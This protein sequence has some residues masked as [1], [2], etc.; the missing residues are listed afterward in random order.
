MFGTG[1]GYALQGS[2]LDLGPPQ[3]D[4]RFASLERTDLGRGSWIDHQAGW[5]RGSDALLADL[6]GALPWRQRERPMYERV[7]PEPRLTSWLPVGT[8]ELPDP[9]GL[10]ADLLGERYSRPIRTIGCNWYRDG[11]D[12]VAWHGDRVPRPGDALVA[13]VSIGARRPFLLRPHGGGPSRRYDLGRGDLLVMG[14]TCQACF[15][16]TVPK[17]AR[18]GPRISVTFRD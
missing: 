8:A 9:L 1:A 4:R 13:I 7:L 12:S 18:A 16:H 17:V 3:P 6:V 11:R 2:L 5:L 15:Q 10:L 14:G